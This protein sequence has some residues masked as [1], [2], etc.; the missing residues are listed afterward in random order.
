[1]SKK[2]KFGIL[3]II[4]CCIITLFIFHFTNRVKIAFVR[5]NEI[6]YGYEGMKEAH[7]LQES[8]TRE[9]SSNI[10]TL[11]LDLQRSINVYNQEYSKL[12]KEERAEKEKMIIIQQD[13]LKQ[14][15]QNAKNAIDKAD[16]ELTQGVLNQI[17]SFIE[18][19]A[20]ENGYNLILG[21]TTSGNI[22]Y[23][24]E[25]MDIT[26]DVLKVLN[27]NYKQSPV[28]SQDKK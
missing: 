19:Y 5:S 8:K 24:E 3:I 20:K 12:N 25:Y 4:S 22:L 27:E 6:V 13:N 9:F 26:D 23:G 21:T 2:I 14:Y 15:Q 11:Q 10:D 18:K 7:A 28:E 16:L 17:N 1:M